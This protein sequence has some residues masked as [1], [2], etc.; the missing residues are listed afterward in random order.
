[1]SRRLVTVAGLGIAVG[2]IAGCSAATSG[3]SDGSADATAIPSVEIPADATR[4]ALSV[5]SDKKEGPF[6]LDGKPINELRVRA[7][8]PYVFDVDNPGT[9]QHNFWIGVAKDLA[10]QAYDRLTGTHLWSEGR[11]S[12]VYTFDAG[13]KV[14]WACTLAG[15]YG[16]MHGDFIVEG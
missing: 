10:G 2:M 15:H 14:Q 16:Q 8:I 4:I 5:P 12:I 11:R 6:R 1:M 3:S 7:G 13:Q 9:R